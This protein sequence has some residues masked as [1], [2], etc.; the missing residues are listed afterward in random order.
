MA[1]HVHR[2]VDQFAL[3]R[4][5][6]GN[7]RTISIHREVNG[8]R[9]A[10][11]SALAGDALATAHD[12]LDMQ[13]CSLLSVA[14]DHLSS[15]KFQVVDANMV[16]AFAGFSLIRSAVE[17]AGIGLWM[18]GPSSRDERVLRT[19][20]TS[21]ESVHDAHVIRCEVEG[22]PYVRPTEEDALI[23]ELRT[24]LDDRPQLIGR[25]LS[26]PPIAKRLQRA[27]A[28]THTH[29][30]L[31][32]LTLWRI[33]SGI[34]HGRREVIASMIPGE[35]I[36]RGEG[37]TEVAMSTSLETLSLFYITAINY[38]TNLADLLTLRNQPA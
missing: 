29:D 38:L 9:R 11:H 37:I 34:T 17:A 5:I 28:Y 10:P 22:K 14:V 7:E 3:D 15:L 13:I 4:F 36:S 2:D 18:L 25:S 35:A 8:F 24:V 6:D 21:Y 30:S 12:P 20:Q 1:E 31:S 33:A 26:P 16:P 19:V 23:A 27:Q 32:L